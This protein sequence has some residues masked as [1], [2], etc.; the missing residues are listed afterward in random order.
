[1]ADSRSTTQWGSTLLTCHTL[2]NLETHLADRLMNEALSIYGSRPFGCLLSIGTGL[3]PNTAVPT[4]NLITNVIALKDALVN[5]L[6]SC[7]R[8]HIQVQPC[9][10]VLPEPGL[11]KYCRFNVGTRIADTKPG[12]ENYDKIIELDD[13]K[14][15]GEFVTITEKYLTEKAIVDRIARCAMRLAKDGEKAA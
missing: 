8:A 13:Y 9:L 4:G 10:E 5:A 6:T 3:Q 15:M 14:K 12:I 11:D 2:F 7:E 1:M